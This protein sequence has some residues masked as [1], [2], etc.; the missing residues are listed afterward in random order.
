[1]LAIFASSASAAVFQLTSN[2]DNSFLDSPGPP[3][4]FSTTVISPYTGSLVL[5]YEAAT[6]LTNGS[7]AWDS[8]T[9]LTLN[10]TFPGSGQTFSHD[11][12]DH[13]SS[14]V[15]IQVIDGNFF[16]TNTDPNGKRSTSESGFANEVWGSAN[17]VNAAKYLFTTQ[18]LN[19]ITRMGFGGYVVE[20]NAL[21]ELI[22]LNTPQPGP[23]GPGVNP[24]TAILRGNYGNPTDNLIPE[25][26]AALLGCL[27]SLALLRRNRR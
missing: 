8:L 15:R 13:P 7:Y 1:M 14:E 5:S 26:S 19:D 17:F 9:N 23:P 10:V 6:E 25:P 2:L 12:L 18:P 21:Y 3:P 24:G 27:G 22:D 4:V 20:Y 11:D 16:F